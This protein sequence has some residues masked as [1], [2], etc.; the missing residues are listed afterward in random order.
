MCI[1]DR[2][3]LGPVLVVVVGRDCRVQSNWSSWACVQPQKLFSKLQLKVP[4]TGSRKVNSINN[5]LVSLHTPPPP[6]IVDCFKSILTGTLYHI[7]QC[8][9]CEGE[10]CYFVWYPECVNGIWLVL[11]LWDF[12]QMISVH[13]CLWW[14]TQQ[15]P[16]HP[17]MCNVHMWW[18]Q[19]LRLAC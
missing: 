7:Q 17:D 16:K 14:Y 5:N 3:L 11:V 1:R 9:D 15:K 13:Q 2:S 19:N 18:L 8:T 4:G 12:E 6:L 10:K